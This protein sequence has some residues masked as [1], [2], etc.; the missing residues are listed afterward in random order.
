VQ[1]LLDRLLGA[2]REAGINLGRH[3]AGDD[4]EDLASEL[5]EQI[6]Q[7]GVDF[8]VDGAAV[9]LAVLDRLVDQGRVLGLLGRGQ[10]QRR[11][12]GCILRLV[13]LDGGKVAGIAYDGLRRS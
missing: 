7:R 12:R 5:H 11:V 6:V 13:L 8:L 3:A 4:L 10:D 1:R 9:A 2:E